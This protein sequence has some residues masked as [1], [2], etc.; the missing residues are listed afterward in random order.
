MKSTIIEFN[1]LKTA[2]IVILIMEVDGETSIMFSNLLPF[3]SR[4]Q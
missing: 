2:N 3:L 4:N 1:Y